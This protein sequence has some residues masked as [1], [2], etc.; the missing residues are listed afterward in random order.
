MSKVAGVHIIK[1]D[2]HF[3][4]KFVNWLAEIWTKRMHVACIK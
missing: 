4:D 3:C 1:R 2:A